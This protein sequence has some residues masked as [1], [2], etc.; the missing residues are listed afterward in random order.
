LEFSDQEVE[1]TC[2]FIEYMVADVT[3]DMCSKMI[4]TKVLNPGWATVANCH[5]W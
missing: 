2:P 3:V 1:V 5:K 4:G